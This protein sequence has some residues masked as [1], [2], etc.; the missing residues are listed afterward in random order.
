MYR[1]YL[2]LCA[3]VVAMLGYA[4]YQNWSLF[5]NDALRDSPAR[6]ATRGSGSS[7]SGHK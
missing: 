4:Q 5:G 1:F 2:A 3:L 7:Y 6:S